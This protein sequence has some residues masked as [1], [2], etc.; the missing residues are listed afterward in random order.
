MGPN[1]CQQW[2]ICHPGK[3]LNQ[4]Y[5]TRTFK[6]EHVKAMLWACVISERLSPLIVCA[7]GGIKADEYMDVLY[8][9]LFSLVDDLLQPP[10]D[11]NMIQVA[12]E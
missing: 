1:F 11:L 5:V 7:E 9:G 8:D 2:V 4:K 3:R 6:N 12:N 10:G